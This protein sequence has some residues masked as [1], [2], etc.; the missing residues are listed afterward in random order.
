MTF[1]FPTRT[2]AK[3]IYTA[4]QEK[5]HIL[6]TAGF[7]ACNL[8]SVVGMLQSPRCLSGVGCLPVLSVD[9]DILHTIGVHVL[10]QRLD[11]AFRVVGVLRC[12]CV[13]AYNH[14]RSPAECS[15]IQTC[16]VSYP[17]MTDAEVAHGLSMNCLMPAGAG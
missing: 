17:Q 4:V 8:L 3:K 10:S 7:T 13:C 15:Y 14:A 1:Q 5:G 6:F 11:R 16:T 2:K 9:S 12:R